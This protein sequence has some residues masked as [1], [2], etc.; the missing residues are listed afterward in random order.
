VLVI[1]SS[2]LFAISVMI[3]LDS[4]GPVLYKSKRIGKKGRNFSS[5]KFRT[6]VV[7]AD[8]LKSFLSTYNE[9]SGPSLKSGMT[10]VSPGSAGT[11][12]K[13]SLDE[14]PQLLNVIKGEMS[15]VGPR[16]L[17]P[18]KWNSTNWNISG[19]GSSA[20][21]HRAVADQGTAGSVVRAVCSA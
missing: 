9:R 12:G 20:R 7:N 4:P 13:F 21:S 1:L 18:A 3:K 15:L 8:K 14:L 11:R 19:G 16:P 6:M 5:S 10:L 2:M 17:L